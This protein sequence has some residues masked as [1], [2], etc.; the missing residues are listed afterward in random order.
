[1]IRVYSPCSRPNKVSSVSS[2][3]ILLN[4]RLSFIESLEYTKAT[5]LTHSRRTSNYTYYR[6]SV[7]CLLQLLIPRLT[8]G[9]LLESNSRYEIVTQLEDTERR[10]L[11]HF[12][13]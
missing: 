4:L 10:P 9:S 8:P 5:K 2:V 3:I 13:L 11:L 7:Q 6:I 1:M 12:C